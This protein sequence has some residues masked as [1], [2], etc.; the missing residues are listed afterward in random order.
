MRKLFS[1]L[2]VLI[3]FVLVSCNNYGK[4][5]KIDDTMEVYLKGDSVNENQAKKMGNYLVK[6]WSDSKQQKSLQLSKD[7]GLYI[8]K[9]VVDEDKFKKDTTV[10]VAFIALK[11]LLETEVFNN[12]QI[13]FVLTDNTFNDIKSY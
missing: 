1:I 11:T 12:Q 10:D 7:S 6:L 2:A 5:V 3:A 4:K 9:M 13:K 8:V